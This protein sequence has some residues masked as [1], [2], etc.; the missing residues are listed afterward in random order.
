MKKWNKLFALLSIALL[1]LFIAACGAQNSDNDE[2]AEE[3]E[4]AEINGE[5]ET[6]EQAE[7]TGDEVVLEI[8]GMGEEGNR[9]GGMVEAFEAANPGITVN[10]TAIPWDQ[11]YD[12]I[13]TAVVGQSGPDIIQMGSTWVSAFG[14]AGG[15]LDISA[16]F[17]NDAFPYIDAHHF[18][19]GALAGV[20]FDGR[21]YGVP[22]YVETRVLYYRNDLLAAVGFDA[23]P[24]TQ[25]ELREV[26]ALLAEQSGHFGMDMNILDSQMLHIFA[27]QNG[28]PMVTDETRTANFSDPILI[29]AMELYASFFQ[30]QLV[31]LPGE[32]EMDITQA[33]AE[34]I[35]PMFISGPWM[36]SVLE[37]AIEAGITD[38]YEWNISVLPA[39]SVN[40][41]SFLGG[42]GLA[43]TSWTDHADEALTFINFMSNPAVQIDW[44]E[45]SNTL[46]AVM[47][48]WENPLLAGNE[49]LAV[50]GEQLNH[51]VGPSMIV[52]HQEIEMLV[53]RALEE[54]VVGGADVEETFNR[55]N[56]DAQ[57]ILD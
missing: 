46:P 4:Q 42:A 6:T 45:M 22:W 55:L 15:L 56:E 27:N 28:L 43:V 7:V 52:E 24:T 34:G 36:I 29:E 54:I 51:A 18:F 9:L 8:W 32:M 5:A 57:A 37:D 41:T 25:D 11:A 49:R 33:F 40:N 31:S 19:D 39:G 12:N 44:F 2:S 20:T 47:E 21:F 3:N 48:S 30:E 14:D 13:V 1:V 50:F 38:E 35:R 16:Y 53:V 10:V 26:A 17:E 23:P